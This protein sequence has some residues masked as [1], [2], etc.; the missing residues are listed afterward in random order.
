[1]TKRVASILYEEPSAKR[2]KKLPAPLTDPRV[3]DIWESFL[4]LK[5]AS[6]GDI[7]TKVK[8][9][10]GDDFI[11]D[12]WSEATTA[13]FSGDDDDELSLANFRVVRVKYLTDGQGTSPPSEIVTEQGD[14]EEVIVVEDEEGIPQGSTSRLPQPPQ[15]IIQDAP[16]LHKHT[17]VA[18]TSAMKSGARRPRKVKNPFIDLEAEQDDDEDELD[19]EEEGDGDIEHR[20]YK[21]ATVTRLPARKN[22]LS[23]TIA[24]IE[25][26]AN[27]RG[28]TSAH[29]VSSVAPRRTTGFIPK[30]RMYKF[31][32]NGK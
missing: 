18:T 24:R 7:V 22:D 10:L 23:E 17:P 27:S 25:V 21:A 20:L 4:T 32:V 3:W 29:H 14:E 31:T 16:A 13:L 5:V 28:S 12:D 30:S 2:A 11:A 15:P 26:S 1:M 19:E 9:Y 8:N 6:Y